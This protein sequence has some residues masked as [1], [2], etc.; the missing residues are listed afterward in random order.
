VEATVVGVST[1]S[2]TGAAGTIAFH[3]NREGRNR[4][5]TIDVATRTLRPLTV[6]QDYHDQEPAWSP[7]CARLAYITTGFDR[8]T[9]DLAVL[10]PN[11]PH[12]PRRLTAT[13][14]DEH[15]PTWSPQPSGGVLFSSEVE[16]AQ[17]IYSID[18]SDGRIE[19]LTP[20]PR[21]RLMPSMSADGFSLAHVV[22][23]ADGLRLVIHDVRSGS[24]TLVS[25]AH[26]DA[27]DPEWAPSG[28]QL[29]FSL[30]EDTEGSL[31]IVDV[32]D[33]ALDAYEFEGYR[34][35]REPTWSPDGRWVVAS[36]RSSNDQAAW[37]L[38]LFDTVTRRASRLTTGA[39]ADR[40]PSWRRCP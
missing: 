4:L 22:G 2:A 34:E 13:P 29:A 38:V 26:Y 5:Y 11:S 28:A 23:M 40:S 24:D 9:F 17:A 35:V 20:P 39:R 3:S 31:A 18:V 1:E 8:S 37:H 25:P 16:G 7:D 21:R 36:A 12:R 10:D 14:A 33:D 15:H 6:G 32:T 30:S 19:R 27:A